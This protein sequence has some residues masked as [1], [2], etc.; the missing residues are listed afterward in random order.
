MK[1]SRLTFTSMASAALLLASLLPAQTTAPAPTLQADLISKVRAA[2]GLEKPGAWRSGITMSGPAQQLGLT[3]K[4]RMLLHP[5]GR[6]FF[7][8]DSLLP[9]Q[10]GFDGTRAWVVDWTGM[11]APVDSSESDVDQLRLAATTGFWLL[12]SFPITRKVL[13]SK[14]GSL[15]VELLVNESRGVVHIDSTTLRPSVFIWSVKGT[16]NEL[17][18]TDY[19]SREG[20]WLPGRIAGTLDHDDV[21]FEVE[22]FVHGADP[23]LFTA[24]T[25]P[26]EDTVF[27][28]DVP[29]KLKLDRTWTGHLLVE[30]SIDGKAKRYFFLDSG[31][32]SHCI[33][34][35][36]AKEL[37]LTSIGKVP[38]SGVG[39]TVRSDVLRPK[40]LQ[41]GPFTQKNPILVSLDLAG[42]AKVLKKDIVGIVGYD[43]FMRAQVELDLEHS[44]ASIHAPGTWKQGEA[45]QREATWSPIRLMSKHPCIECRFEGDRK[46]WFRIDTGA[47]GTVTFHSNYVDDEKLLEDRK[48]TRASSGGVG[49][50]IVVLDGRLAWFEIGG[51]RFEKPMV[52]FS[53]SKEGIFSQSV[54]AGNIGVHFLKPFRLLFD[55]PNMRLGLLKK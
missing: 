28:A 14:D 49:G 3:H 38:A 31:A 5:D 19:A 33:D 40:T 34:K 23:K 27:D 47:N 52:R 17:R 24:R 16:K 43:L 1:F 32:G 6:Y 30:T 7:E 37:R 44:S 29:A 39:G 42:I 10:A 45:T 20:L 8:L 51:H 36:Y 55:Y 11:P 13:P 18:L 35:T 9:M 50:N 48:T 26:P 21:V 54:L 4:C 46:A 2:C 15:R 53:R 25:Q 41:V 22:Q 12:D